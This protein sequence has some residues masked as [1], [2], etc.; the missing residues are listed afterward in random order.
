MNPSVLMPL[1]LYL[2]KMFVGFCDYQTG[3]LTD[4]H[5]D[6]VNQSIVFINF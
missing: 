5:S 2:V 1:L 3:W 4:T 6:I